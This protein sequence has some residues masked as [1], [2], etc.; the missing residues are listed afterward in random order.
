LASDDKQLVRRARRGDEQAFRA[1]MEKYQRKVFAIAY[2]MVRNPELAM[3]ISQEAFIKVHRYLDHFQGTSSFYTWLYRIVVNVSIDS[4][5]KESRHASVDYDDALN[6]REPDDAEAWIVPRVLDG[7]PL[8]ACDRKELSGRIAAAFESLGEKHRA[9]L[10]LRE[11]DGLSYEEIAR[12]LKINKGTVMSRLHHARKNMQEALKDYL[13]ERGDN[14]SSATG[15]ARP[16][17]AMVDEVSD[18]TGV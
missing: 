7:N 18:A 4:I 8:Q 5:R 10:S 3:D 2:G 14:L 12:V 16:S 13:A 9:V 15:E 17:E 11:V 6:R 1:L